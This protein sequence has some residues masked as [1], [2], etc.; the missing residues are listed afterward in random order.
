[1]PAVPQYLYLVVL[2][3]GVLESL[4]VQAQGNVAPW[5]EEEGWV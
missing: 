1:M 5:L 4:Q 3:E 2:E